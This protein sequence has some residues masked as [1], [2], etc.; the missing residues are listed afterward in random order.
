MADEKYGVRLA[1]DVSD[2]DGMGLE[3]TD[4]RTGETLAE[5][6]QDDTSG[7]RTVTIFGDRALAL[8]DLEW[9]LRQASQRL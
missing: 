2:R 6:F 3:L 1:S 7:V 8:A 5:V 9:F 4:R